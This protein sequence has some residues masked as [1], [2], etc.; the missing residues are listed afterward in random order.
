MLDLLI[1]R[2]SAAA[3]T[4][5]APTDQQL[6]SILRAAAS[7][8]DHNKLRPYRFVVIRGEAR[9]RFG[10]ALAAAAV[11]AGADDITIGKARRKP[12]FGP[13]LVAIIASPVTHDSV[14]VW[15][16]VATASLT[17]YAMV[18]AAAAVD[19]G[20]V[21][22]S[23]RHL[24]EAP[25]TRL[26]DMGPDE[27]LLGWI[28]MG[29]VPLREGRPMRPK[30]QAERPA[31][32]VS[33][34]A[35]DPLIGVAELAARLAARLAAPDVVVCDVRWHLGAPERGRTEYAQ[36]R[37]PGARYVDLDT[38][39]ADHGVQGRGRHPLPDPLVFAARMGGLGIGPDTT[40]IAYDDGSGVPAS[41]L[42]WMLDALG[43]ASVRLL[44]GGIAAWRGAGLPLED[45]DPVT[46]VPAT[47]SL[48]T[49][50]PRTI[51]REELAGRIGDLMLL[52]VRA[53]ERYRGETEPVDPK[54]GHIP[55][56]ISAP[57]VANA[58]ADG[59]LRPAD[60]LAQR[61]VDLG[62]D[63]GEVVVSCGSGV[64]ACHTALAIRRAGLPDPI[65]YAGSYSDWVTAGLPVVTG[66]EPRPEG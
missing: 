52:D 40:V 55:G 30:D 33:H 10:A 27:R 18:L 43:H 7:V 41:R 11:A 21:W 25:V 50:W 58:G 23:G 12:F 60:E 1:G 38:D 47:L 44:D 65:L 51:E 62:A 20:A 61:F 13:L 31:P 3:L 54:P 5:P 22:K 45:G 63:T 48:A 49:V 32:R 39:L 46:H 64:T 17:G 28:N 34:L 6:A 29:T 56:A 19:V 66:N 15:E 2:H 37:I 9:Q 8:P 36:E 35:P 24:D 16:Q 53:A 4:T 14:P 59:L 26:L 42:W 57:S